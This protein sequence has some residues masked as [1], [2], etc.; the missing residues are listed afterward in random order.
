MPGKDWAWPGVTKMDCN[1]W[2]KKGEAPPVVA[3][4][5]PRG[6]DSLV[7]QRVRT[8]WYPIRGAA[9]V[10]FYQKSSRSKQASHD[11]EQF[12]LAIQDA[13]DKVQTFGL[14]EAHA[15]PLVSRGKGYPVHRKPAYAAWR[16][17]AE[18]EL[19]TPNSFPAIVLDVDTG[20]Q[21]YLTVALGSPA[22]R[23]PNWI[24]TNPITGHAHVVYCLRH[25]ILRGQKARKTPMQYHAR[26]AEYY[27]AAYD[28]DRGY[29]G[30]LTHNPVH[31]KW[32]TSWLREAP[33]TLAELGEAIPKGWRTPPKPTTPEGRNCALFRAAM[34][35]F[36]KPSNWEASTDLG[37]VLAWV[38]QAFR[39]WY[40]QHGVIQG[41]HR[42]ECLWIAKSVVGYC[43]RNLASGDTQQNFSF[44]QA[45]R[46]RKSGTKRRERTA[47][48]DAEI[49]ACVEAGES[50]RSLARRFGL[51]E[52]TVRHI[53][54]RGAG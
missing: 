18:I 35:W 17:Y 5:V 15:F 27:R 21:D 51:D 1:V 29:M 44:M 52:S 49:V 33:Y 20:P 3:E 22:V 8:R 36:G 23:V 16:Y 6:A 24:V 40:G 53:A 11:T 43:R 37:D 12:S 38:E 2:Y 32:L 47:E 34:R 54:R 45:E 9:T 14:Q 48:R 50:M 4:K 25:P 28:G 39:E 46:G 13:P 41:W 7:E 26:I 19:R 10:P 30:V 31:R 42:N